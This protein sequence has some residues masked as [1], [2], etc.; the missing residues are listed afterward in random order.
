MDTLLSYNLRY[1]LEPTAEDLEEERQREAEAAAAAED[2][3][4]GGG[5]QR[6]RGAPP[7]P[8]LRFTPAVHR[9]CAFTVSLV[10]CCGRQ[11]GVQG[12]GDTT[13]CQAIAMCCLD[14]W[15]LGP[16]LAALPAC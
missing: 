14:A 15:M 3:Q 11:V 4:A 8:P 9:A 5:A 10:L 1:C 2:G 12:L 13:C 16:L 6:V 7:D